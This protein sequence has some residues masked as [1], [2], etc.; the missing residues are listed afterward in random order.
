MFKEYSKDDFSEIKCTDINTLNK[1]ME[2][3]EKIQSKNRSN[4][5]KDSEFRKII[6]INLKEK[7]KQ[8]VLNAILN[9][10]DE[11]E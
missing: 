6:T 4:I 9:N 5:K 3:K 8:N 2:E 1:N 11:I 10:V 7:S